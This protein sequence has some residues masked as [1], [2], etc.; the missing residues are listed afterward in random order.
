M[1]TSSRSLLDRRRPAPPGARSAARAAPRRLAG[2]DGLRGLAVVAVVAYH[3]GALRGGFLGVDLFFVV[4]GF[5]ITRMLTLRQARG[6]PVTLRWFWRRR[7]RRLLPAVLV[8]VAAVVIVVARVDGGSLLDRTR[9]QGLSAL[10]YVNNWYDLFAH[11]GYFDVALARTPLNHLWSLSIEEQFY[12]VWPVLFIA[13]SGRRRGMAALLAL[14]SGLI[15]LSMSLAPFWDVRSG[16]ARAYLGTD[17]RVGAILLGAV[18]GLV[19]SGHELRGTRWSARSLWGVRLACAGAALFL[20]LE[21]V[22]ADVTSAGLYRGGLAAAGVAAAVIVAGIVVDGDVVGSVLGIRPL[23]WVGRLSYSL[24]LWHV[25]IVVL[26]TENHTGLRGAQLV[27]VQ[28]LL[29]TA[30]TLA[31]YYLIERPIHLDGL[32]MSRSV[33]AGLAGA[34]CVVAVLG[35]PRLVRGPAP[36]GPDIAAPVRARGFSA[37]EVQDLR[38]LVVGDSWGIRTGLG[39]AQMPAPHPARVMQLAQPSCGIAD[40]VEEINYQTGGAFTPTAQCLAW[41]TSWSRAVQDKPSFAVLQVGNWDQAKQRL[42]PGGGWLTACDAAFRS[43]YDHSLDEAIAILTAGGTPVFVPT[44]RDNDGVLRA[45]SDCMNSMLRDAAS[46]HASGGVHLL[47]LDGLL[48]P[49]HHCATTLDGHPTY[50]ETGHISFDALPTVNRWVFA[51]VGAVLGSQVPGTDLWAATREAPPTAPGTEPDRP[52]AAALEGEVSRAASALA[53]AGSPGAAPRPAPAGDVL[54]AVP[55]IRS[56]AGDPALVQQL[57]ASMGSAARS[58]ALSAGETGR[59]ATFAYQADGQADAA[60]VALQ[61]LAL[62][63]GGQMIVDEDNL[64]HFALGDVTLS[65]RRTWQRLSLTVITGGEAQNRVDL[66]RAALGQLG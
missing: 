52:G 28:L 10:A 57:S 4:S 59:V 18:L 11:I 6:E 31:S 2:L 61:Q 39:M 21:W 42:T 13:F 44:V 9:G 8:L 41:R 58:V 15:V 37:A 12:V 30:T 47:D 55:P 7:F 33:L 40:P 16:Y 22:T 35:L 64:K 65:F 56:S 60:A 1:P 36:A 5:V 17:S 29:I 51:E 45:R 66:A 54:F 3:F 23:A 19:L 34:A 24:Y 14:T 62:D 48:C 27:T 49:G 38:V 43:R 20:T 50:D 53:G 63:G 26:V 46:R 32:T 25:P